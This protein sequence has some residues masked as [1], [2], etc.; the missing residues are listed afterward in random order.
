M[1]EIGFG[2]DPGA[3]AVVTRLLGLGPIVGRLLSFSIAVLVTF[4]MNRR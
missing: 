1:G 4:E 2:A 3:L